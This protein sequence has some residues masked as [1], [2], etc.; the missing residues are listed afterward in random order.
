MFGYSFPVRNELIISKSSGFTLIELMLSM[1][2][3]AILSASTIQIARFTDTQKNLTLAADQ[4]RVGIRTAQGYALSVPN[5]TSHI[6]SFG[7]SAS[8]SNYRIFYTSVSD[9]DYKNDPSNACATHYQDTPGTELSTGSLPTGVQF[10]TDRSV[11]FKVPYGEVVNS[12][13]VDFSLVGG[14]TTKP[15]SVSA[16]GKID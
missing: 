5:T 8:G 9:N 10:N 11:W 4:V 14:G 12:A 16:Q 2:I 1:A 6:C 7:F 15:V 3:L 13:T